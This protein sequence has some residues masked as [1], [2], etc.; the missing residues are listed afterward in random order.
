VSERDVVI[1]AKLGIHSRHELVALVSQAGASKG[2]LPLKTRS[3]REVP[4]D[5]PGASLASTLRHERA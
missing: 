1:Y 2:R 3:V 4:V 5:D